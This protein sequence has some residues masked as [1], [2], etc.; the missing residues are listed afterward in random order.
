MIRY[1]FFMVMGLLFTYQSGMGQKVPVTVYLTSTSDYCGGAKPDE[2]ILQSLQ[3]PS[4]IAHKTIYVK[5]GNK[6]SRKRVIACATSDDS[7]KIVFRL[8]PGTYCLVDSLKMNDP[9]IPANTKEKIFDADCI[10]KQWCNC[11]QI[12]N[13]R[14]K[15]TSVV[16]INYHRHCVFNEPCVDYRGP[17][18]SMPHK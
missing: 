9:V 3:Q 14:K 17:L 5:H 1:V 8:K 16:K 4:A 13:I 11:D 7:G 10:K 15:N 18:P 6:N 2:T 12:L